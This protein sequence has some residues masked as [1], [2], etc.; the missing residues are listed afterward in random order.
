MSACTQPGCGGFIEDGYC[1]VCGM[2][3]EASA[4]T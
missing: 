3:P 1:N 2:P 4:P